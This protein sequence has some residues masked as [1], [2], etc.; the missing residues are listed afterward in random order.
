MASFQIHLNGKHCCQRGVRFKTLGPSDIDKI[1]LDAAK[2]IGPEGTMIE[3]RKAEWLMGVKQ[4]L[5]HI[6]DPC[7]DIE[8]AK[9]R[10]VTM[11]DLDGENYDG[12]FGSRDHSFLVQ[13]YREYHEVTQEDV[14]KIM[15]KALPVS[16]D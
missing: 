8:T 15:G 14:D 4:M 6:S 3:L 10:K 12:L 13:L 2:V 11:Q 5:T 16:E 9:F 7:T 1:T